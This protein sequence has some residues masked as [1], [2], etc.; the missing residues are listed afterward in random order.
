M[1][2]LR[3]EN[4]CGMEPDEINGEHKNNQASTC[5]INRLPNEL[6]KAYQLPT[7]VQFDEAV[8]LGYE[9]KENGDDRKAREKRQAGAGLV[10]AEKRKWSDVKNSRSSLQQGNDSSSSD[11]EV[12]ELFSK[13]QRS[14]HSNRGSQKE[15]WHQKSLRCSKVRPCDRKR[16]RLASEDQM[17]SHR[18]SL[19]FEK[20]QQVI[21]NKTRN[22][23]LPKSKKSCKV[24]K[25][26]NPAA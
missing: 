4:V 12:K 5:F 24:R 25:K 11:E 3:T 13:Q 8:K 14:E 9:N 26:K 18:P 2:F 6:V 17:Y 7:E 10:Y 16:H 19:D 20:M 15:N 1:F 22:F 21:E 23:L